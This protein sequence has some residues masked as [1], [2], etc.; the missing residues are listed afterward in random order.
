MPISAAPELCANGVAVKSTGVADLDLMAMPFQNTSC[1]PVT[2]AV[3]KCYRS[4]ATTS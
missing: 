1:R 2:L 3:T 4:S